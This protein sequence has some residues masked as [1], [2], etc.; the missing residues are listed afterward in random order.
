MKQWILI[1]VIVLFS[2]IMRADN[3]KD[4]DIEREYFEKLHTTRA[5]FIRWIHEEHPCSP[6]ITED[7]W[8]PVYR[9]V[10]KKMYYRA[11]EEDRRKKDVRW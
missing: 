5:L 6:E 7:P 4:N 2:S 11:L 10:A 9:E 8:Y 3:M 1:A